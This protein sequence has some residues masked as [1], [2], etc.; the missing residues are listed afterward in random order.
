MCTDNNWFLQM[1]DVIGAATAGQNY[2]RSCVDNT[3]SY[4]NT[5]SIPKLVQNRVRTWYEYTWD[6]QG[7]LGEGFQFQL[8][9]MSESGCTDTDI[10]QN[11][12][13]SFS[14]LH[15]GSERRLLNLPWKRKKLQSNMILTTSQ[16]NKQNINKYS[17]TLINVLVIIL[18]KIY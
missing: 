6:S 9:S 7:M 4:M 14:E 13:F 8:L 17:Q 1:R 3:V 18:D 10:Q 12:H 11:P 16:I 15:V 2:F 5:Y